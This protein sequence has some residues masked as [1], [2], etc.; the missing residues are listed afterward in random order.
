MP[1]VTRISTT[2]TARYSPANGAVDSFWLDNRMPGRRESRAADITLDREDRGFFFSVFATQSLSKDSFRDVEA[3]KHALEKTHMEIKHSSKSIDNQIPDL[4]ECSVGVAGRV[5]VQHE[6]VRQPF[7]A[8]IIVKDSEIAAVTTGR[9]CAYLYRDQTLFPLTKD[10]LGFDSVDANGNRVPNLQIYCAGVAGTVRY[11]HIAQL[12]VDDCVILCNREVIDAIGQKE[13]LQILDEAYDQSDAAGMV[14]T[15]AA[16]K[17]PGTPLQFMIGF[18]EGISEGDR[19]VRNLLVPKISK[20]APK[21][22]AKAIVLDNEH[23]RSDT[24][25]IYIEQYD[26]DDDDDDDEEYLEDEDYEDEAPGAKRLA[27]MAIIAIILIVCGIVIYTL[28]NKEP[29]EEESGTLPTPTIDI[30]ESNP[31]SGEITISPEPTLEPTAVPEPTSEIL[32]THTIVPGQL[33]TNI[34]NEYYGS[35]EAKYLNA[36][37]EANKEKYPD[38]TLSYY[39]QGWVIEIPAVD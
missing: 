8:G 26:L 33:L 3:V 13:L 30:S 28:L 20:N 36:I 38:F 32:A 5:S 2:V 7:F 11:S 25:D 21:A 22:T 29:D 39:Q 15:E 16:A 24:D 34:A 12:Q 10:D 18:V 27:L 23:E 1:K 4:A 14:I 31:D 37:V 19:S 6:G 17:L 35:A 9:G